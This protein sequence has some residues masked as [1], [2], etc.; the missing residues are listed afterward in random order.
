M[1]PVPPPL[2]RYLP[3]APYLLLD[4]RRIGERDPPSTDLVTSLGRMEREPSPENL[5]RVMRGEGADGH[6]AICRKGHREDSPE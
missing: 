6:G 3:R 4:L 2:E 5:R 1:A